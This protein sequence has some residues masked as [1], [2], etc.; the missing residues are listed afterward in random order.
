MVHVAEYFAGIGLAKM[1]LEA[2]GH[3]VTWSNDISAKKHAQFSGHY[4]KEAHHVYNV[5]DLGSVTVEDIPAGIELAWASFPCTDLSLAGSRGGLHKGASAA[6]WHFIKNIARLRDRRPQTIV[7]ENVTGFASSRSGKDIRTAI[8]SLNGLGYSVDVLS[9]DA[10]RFVPQSRPRLFIIGQRKPGLT[11]DL[12]SVLRPKWLDSIFDDEDLITHRAALPL[13]PE[14]LTEGFTDLAERLD[15]ADS[16]W[17]G[18]DRVLALLSSLSDLQNERLNQ[19]LSTPGRNFRTAY[20]RMRSGTPR[21]E[22]KRDDIA[23]CLRTAGGGSSRQ[24]VVESYEGQVR[25]R[26]M[27]PR[28]YAA[29][30]GAPMYRISPALSPNEAYSGFGDAVCVPVVTWLATH[31]VAPEVPEPS[32]VSVGQVELARSA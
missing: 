15:D 14:L 5:G 11:E 13:V 32:T 17:W 28:E 10:R 7:L 22:I 23:G 2:A 30:M 9:I 31:F 16:R 21:W 1:G 20:R 3:T 26:W 6:Y 27:T 4:G 24:A 25:V 12:P 19:L 18:E 29:L 8:A